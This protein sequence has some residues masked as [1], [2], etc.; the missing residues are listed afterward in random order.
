MIVSGLEPVPRVARMIGHAESQPVP[1][2]NPGP[3][4]DDVVHGVLVGGIA[5]V[6]VDVQIS[7]D[8]LV[9]NKNKSG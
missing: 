4:A 3:R 7:L 5:Q 6:Q 9:L 1:P 2:H 8:D